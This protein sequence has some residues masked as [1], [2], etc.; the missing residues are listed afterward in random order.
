MLKKILCKFSYA[1]VSCKF[2]RSLT[3]MVK[4]M[5][6]DKTAAEQLRLIQQ[7]DEE[8]RQNIFK[9]IAKMLTIKNSKALLIKNISMQKSRSPAEPGFCF[10]YLLFF[11]RFMAL[12]F[13]Y[14]LFKLSVSV[15]VPTKKIDVF[16]SG[17]S[18]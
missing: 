8:D 11:N 16:N 9:L 14:A 3:M 4:V 7:V 10:F 6:E 18:S 2:I 5:I 1:S 13:S 12:R 17:C 15:E